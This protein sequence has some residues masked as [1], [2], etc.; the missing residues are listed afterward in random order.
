MVCEGFSLTANATLPLSK[1]SESLAALG[2]IGAL[3]DP[4]LSLMKWDQLRYGGATKG[5]GEQVFAIEY[6]LIKR[7]V[8]GKSMLTGPMAEWGSGMFGNGG[9]ANLANNQSMVLDYQLADE[10]EEL[11]PQ[12]QLMFVE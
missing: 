11:L 7:K 1:F 10:L 4:Q 2:Y 5:V 8:F 3:K 6:R 9:D 12:Y